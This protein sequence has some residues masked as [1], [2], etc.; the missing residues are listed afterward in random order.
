MFLLTVFCFLFLLL[1]VSAAAGRP[2]LSPSVAAVC[3]RG[4]RR[5]YDLYARFAWK[6]VGVLRVGDWLDEMWVGWVCGLG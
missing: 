1:A 5:A 2:P 6:F 4:S 3:R